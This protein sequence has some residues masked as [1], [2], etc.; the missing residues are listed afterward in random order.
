MPLMHVAAMN[1][2]SIAET[3]GRGKPNSSKFAL[4]LTWGFTA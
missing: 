4:L 1:V 3:L 2:I